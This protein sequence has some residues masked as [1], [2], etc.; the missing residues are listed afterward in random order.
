[1]GQTTKVSSKGKLCSKVEEIPLL[2]V[3]DKV[4]TQEELGFSSR[5]KRS[6]GKNRRRLP[7]RET[8]L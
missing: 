4:M 7:K 6:R 2:A 1:M 8:F 3:V 5:D